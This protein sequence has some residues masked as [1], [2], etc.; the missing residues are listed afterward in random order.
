MPTGFPEPYWRLLSPAERF[1]LK[2]LEVEQH[3]EY[4]SGV[5]Q[6]MAR[7]FG[8]REYKN[9]LNAGKAN[10]T[11]LKTALEFKNKELHTEGFGQSLVRQLLY[12]TYETSRDLAPKDGR[13][14]LYQNDYIADYWSSRALMIHLLGFIEDRVATLAHWEKDREALRLLKGYL[15]NDRI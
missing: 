4:R 10:Q 15:E 14:W 7:G 8:L 11:R 1:Y 12:A 13:Q 5:Y 2:G 3:G 9:V 6:E